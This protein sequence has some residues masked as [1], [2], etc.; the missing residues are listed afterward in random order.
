VQ[1][2][3]IGR[4][5][6]RSSSGSTPHDR[7]TIPQICSSCPLALDR[8]RQS[9]LRYPAVVSNRANTHRVRRQSPPIHPPLRSRTTSAIASPTISHSA[10]GTQIPITRRTTNVSLPAVSSL[11]GLR[12]PAPPCAAPPSWG[13]HPKTLY[14]AYRCQVESGGAVESFCHVTRL[15]LRHGQLPCSAALSGQSPIAAC[16]APKARGLTANARSEPS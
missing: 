12:T 10:R 1:R 16:G 9:A 3:D 4:Q 14:G 15:H 7:P 13:R 8:R 6:Q 5:V 11:G 2:H